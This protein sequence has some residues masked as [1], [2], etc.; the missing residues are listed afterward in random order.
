MLFPARSCTSSCTSSFIITT[1][2]ETPKINEHY[3]VGKKHPKLNIK[4]KKHAHTRTIERLSL[5]PERL[6]EYPHQ[7]L[8]YFLFIYLFIYLF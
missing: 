1:I 6:T 4:T 2:L 8:L 5:I 7:I 3:S